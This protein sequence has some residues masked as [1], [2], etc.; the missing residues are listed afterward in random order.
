MSERARN[1]LIFYYS[2]MPNIIHSDY[3]TKKYGLMMCGLSEEV[4]EERCRP[5]K[6]SEEEKEQMMIEYHKKEQKELKQYNRWR[7]KELEKER[8]AGLRGG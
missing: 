2:Q 1:E 8:V 3:L 4:A 5:R 7:K 6:V